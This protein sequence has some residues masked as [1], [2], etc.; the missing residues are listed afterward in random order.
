M[1]DPPTHFRLAIIGVQE[2]E[3]A[4]QV[5]AD[6]E[7]VAEGVLLHVTGHYITSL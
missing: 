7:T 1:Q 3:E 4:G 6:I 5:H 2:F